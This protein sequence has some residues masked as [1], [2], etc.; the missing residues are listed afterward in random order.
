KDFLNTVYTKKYLSASAEGINYPTYPYTTVSLTLP[1][2]GNKVATPAVQKNILFNLNKNYHFLNDIATLDIIVNNINKRPVYFT[3]R[4]SN[5]SFEKNLMQKGIVYKLI[6]E[7]VDLPLQKNAEVK[8]LEKFI[9]EKH[10]PVLSND[11]GI[12]SFDGDNTFFGLYYS[13][14]N[15]Y[16]GKRDTVTFKKWLYKLNATC[17]KINSTQIPVAQILAYYFIEAGDTKKGLAITDQYAQWLNN[18][19]TKPGSLTGYYSKE[20]YT[21]ELNRTKSYL[22]SKGLTSALIDRLF[23]NIFDD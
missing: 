21:D 16:L 11:I 19:Y 14:F 8:G 9:H 20:K 22:V 18:A 7:D 5:L 2:P 1:A 17:P 15:Y 10:I 3:S 6:A 12:T 4:Y 13:I 23:V